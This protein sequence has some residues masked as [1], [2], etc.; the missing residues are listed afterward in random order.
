M[1]LALYGKLFAKRDFIA[2]NVPRGFLDTFEPWLQGALSASRL[3][4]GTGWQK[5]YF[6]API[7]RFHLGPGHCGRALLGALMPSV[8]GVGRSFPLVA[9]AAAPAGRTF[10][11]PLLDAQESW[12][13]A[14]ET[15]L[16]S[17][18]ETDD[19]SSV[20]AALAA[21]DAP[22]SADLPPPPKYVTSLLGSAAALGG[23]WTTAPAE[24][25]S[26]ADAHLG[27]LFSSFWWT[28]GGLAFPPSA[29]YGRNLP[30]AEAFAGFL[31][32][33]AFV[34]LSIGVET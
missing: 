25:A 23:S 28:A 7:W 9:F 11:S 19:F 32:G 5:A 30:D 17:T 1:P 20:I 2:E 24:A 13:N 31:T 15:F 33:S 26:A 27:T 14:V 34:R 22:A 18:L 4:L 29:L 8:D 3:S 6:E 10:A 16:L 21:L 12:F